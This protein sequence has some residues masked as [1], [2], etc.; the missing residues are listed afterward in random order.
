MPETMRVQFAT[1]LLMQGV[2]RDA[3]DAVARVDETCRRER[4][5][6]NGILVKVI[7][8]LREILGEKVEKRY[9]YLTRDGRGL[10]RPSKD[11][12]REMMGEMPVDPK[13]IANVMM[14]E[15]GQ[16]WLLPF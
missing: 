4:E 9:V 1:V 6:V 7:Q 3:M 5:T 10:Y 14:S 11:L 8:R 15:E 2:T 16:R 13:V 12:G